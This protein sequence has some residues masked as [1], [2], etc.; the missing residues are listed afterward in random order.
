MSDRESGSRPSSLDRLVQLVPVL[1][2][3]GIA[4]A[5]V[6]TVV[7][8]E[9]AG[10][11][12]LAP[13]TLSDVL[14][15]AWSI[16]PYF[17]FT[18]FMIMGIWPIFRLIDRDQAVKPDAIVEPA[19]LNRWSL[20]PPIAATFGTP[21]G[22][23]LLHETG[24]LVD[25]GWMTIV[26][27]LIHVYGVVVLFQKVMPQTL[28][29]LY[30]QIIWVLGYNAFLVLI[31][32]SAID[33]ISAIKAEENVL[34]RYGDRHF[35]CGKLITIGERGVIVFEPTSRSHKFIKSDAVKSI[36]DPSTCKPARRWTA[37]QKELKK[38]AGPEA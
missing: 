28:D 38:P 16:T 34:V 11:R 27:Y 29:D 30:R 6:H 20:V 17:V 24:F 7:Y 35:F 1:S 13:L 22:M 21:V 15:K 19:S 3:L 12:T 31:L 32:L 37:P 14:S 9:F 4:G 26:G 25:H 36:E 33:G 5:V 18:A 23:Y 2:V 10:A 8:L